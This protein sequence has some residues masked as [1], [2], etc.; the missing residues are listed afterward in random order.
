MSIFTNPK[1]KVFTTSG[2]LASGYKVYFFE[3]GTSTPKNTYPTAADAAALT[4]ANANPVVLDSNGEAEIWPTTGQYRIRIDSDVD[5]TQ[6]GFPIDAIE[7]AG[8]TLGAGEDLTLSSTSDI[9]VNTNKFIVRGA[10]GNTTVDGTLTANSTFTLS[11][12]IQMANAKS[13]TWRNV[14]NTAY[15]DVV[16]LDASD[17]AVIDSGSG[18]TTI[19]KSAGSTAITVDSSQNVGVGGSPTAQL[20]SYADDTSTSPII[21]AEQDGTGDA[22]MSFLLTGGQE[23]VMG[24]DNS[25]SDKFKISDSAVLGTTDR[26]SIDTAGAIELYGNTTI[27]KTTA[28]EFKVFYDALVPTATTFA[29]IEMSGR[30]TSLNSR[31]GASIKFL[32]GN[33]VSDA[34]ETDIIF[35]TTL[36]NANENTERMRLL[37]SGELGVGISSPDGT[38]H[39]HTATAGSVTASSSAS[40]LIVENSGN[41]GISMLG[42]DASDINLY[43][44]SPT[45]NTGAVLRW[46]HDNALVQ[47]GTAVSSGEVAIM[48][49]AFTEAVRIDSN[50]KTTFKASTTSAASVNIPSGTAPTSPANGDMWFDGTNYKGRIGGATVTFTTT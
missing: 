19:I 15:V 39:V 41:T 43:F 44:G 34:L 37:S 27:S 24:I 42:P 45:S 2:G 12:D 13:A 40:D 10:T 7:G 31:V 21:R 33:Q 28:G 23:M 16:T 30:D 20:S 4:N 8:I 49:D 9:L 35:S 50:G 47:I 17:N 14:G 29:Q 38:A 3:T 26:L 1:F 11:D 46:N 6:T 22:S 18:A 32:S 48:S 5:V 25:D 36:N